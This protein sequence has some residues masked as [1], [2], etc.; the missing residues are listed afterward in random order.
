MKNAEILH[1]IG[2]TNLTSF[3]ELSELERDFFCRMVD[4]CVL[5]NEDTEFREG[6]VYLD[7][8]SRLNNCTVY[9]TVLGMY[10]KKGVKK[11]IKEWKKE[12]GFK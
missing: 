5:E 3:N 1:G 12:N 9:E 4:E 6:L 10:T 8:Y 7:E 2:K 11:R